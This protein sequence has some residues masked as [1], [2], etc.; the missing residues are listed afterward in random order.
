[1]FRGLLANF[2][3]NRIANSLVNSIVSNLVNLFVDSRGF[4][5]SIREEGFEVARARTEGGPTPIP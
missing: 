1:M 3:V 5:R 4:A 2:V